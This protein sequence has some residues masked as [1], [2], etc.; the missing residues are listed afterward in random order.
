MYSKFS[1]P[2]VRLRLTRKK[3]IFGHSLIYRNSYVFFKFEFNLLPILMLKFKFHVLR[4]KILNWKMLL[5]VVASNFFFYL[6]K[7]VIIE[8]KEH[9]PS[10]YLISRDWTFRT[11]NIQYLKQFPNWSIII[12]HCWVLH[13]QILEYPWH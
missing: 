1:W 3:Q 9:H 5:G 8:I 6:S 2:N 4:L 7:I 10:Q 11:L 12:K 13:K